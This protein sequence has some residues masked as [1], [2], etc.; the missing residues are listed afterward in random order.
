MKKEAILIIMGLIIVLFAIEV[1]AAGSSGNSQ[2]SS[3][4]GLQQAANH[5]ANNSAAQPVA[6]CEAKTT[7]KERVK[8]RLEKRIR[9]AQGNQIHESCRRLG[10]ADKEN[11]RRL[12]QEIQGCYEK[13]GTE[14]DRCFKLKTGFA[15]SAVSGHGVNKEAARGYLVSLLYDLEQ[16]VEDKVEQ[17]VITSDQGAALV[18]KIIQI[19]EKILNKAPGSEIRPLIR[20]LKQ[21]WRQTFGPANQNNRT[22]NQS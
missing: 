21:L 16:K 2:G 13:R 8:C 6:G 5:S 14:K 12:Y 15:A 11:C 9:Y 22:G 17:G 20:E 4:T 7:I 3:T 1:Y 18:D 19:K 10:A